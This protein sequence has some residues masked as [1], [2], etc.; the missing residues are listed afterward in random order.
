[1]GATANILSFWTP[2]FP[3]L[4]VIAAVGLILFGRRLPEVGRSLG[5]SIVEFKRGLQGLKDEVDQSVDAIDDEMTQSKANSTGSTTD[6]SESG[7]GNT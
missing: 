4:V 7:G 3:E 1:M 5:K 2:G 6:N